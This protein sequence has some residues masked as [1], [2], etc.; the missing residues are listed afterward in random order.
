MEV[1]IVDLTLLV[2]F[3]EYSGDGTVFKSIS[4]HDCM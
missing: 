4:E 1:S 2:A 3:R